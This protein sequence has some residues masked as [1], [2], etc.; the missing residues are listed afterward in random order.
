MPVRPPGRHNFK[1]YL[2]SAIIGAVFGGLALLLFSVFLWFLQLPVM[3]GDNFALTAFGAA[4]LAAGFTAGKLKQRGGLVHGLKAALLLLFAL[5]AVSF[6]I[7]DLSGDFLIGRL[8]VTVI[9]GCMGGV[10]GVNKR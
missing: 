5:A 4:C 9:C 8:T 10:L 1:I 2:L 3:F 6:V 7:G